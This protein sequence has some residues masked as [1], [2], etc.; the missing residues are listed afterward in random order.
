MDVQAHQ[1]I[2]RFI[3]VSFLRGNIS[4]FV[5]Y[6]ADVLSVTSVP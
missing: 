1:L 6:N 5:Q 4:V 3:V 2:T